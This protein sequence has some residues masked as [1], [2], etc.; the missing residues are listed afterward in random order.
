MP[1]KYD[2]T[3]VLDLEEEAKLLEYLAKHDIRDHVAAMFGLKAGLRIG[4]LLQLQVRDLTVT[5]QVTHELLL[6]KATTKRHKQRWIP[7]N[8]ELRQSIKN[9]IRWKKA[10]GESL[11]PEAPLLCNLKGD[12][13]YGSRDYQR[14]LQA[15]GWKVLGR[16]IIPHDLRHTFATRLMRKGNIRALQELLG[17]TK[18]EYTQLYTHP[19]RQDLKD[20]VGP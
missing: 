2:L 4:E 12:R 5:D 3:R 19:N 1:D 9:L 8:A 14:H 10:K 6:R 7:L 11:D 15:A 17:H 18:L 16:R 13:P 20:L